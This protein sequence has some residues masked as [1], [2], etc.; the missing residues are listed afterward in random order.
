L[1]AEVEGLALMLLFMGLGAIAEMA[2]NRLKEGKGP[3]SLGE[4]LR[5]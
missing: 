1:L 3:T 4:A 2:K 5:E